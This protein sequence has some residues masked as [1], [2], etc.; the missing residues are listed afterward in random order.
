M[1]HRQK[2]V[3]F[4]GNEVRVLQFTQNFCDHT[5]RDELFLP[6][7]V[8]REWSSRRLVAESLRCD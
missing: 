4:S 2:G 3:G 8:G 6:S 5:R 1:D 7:S